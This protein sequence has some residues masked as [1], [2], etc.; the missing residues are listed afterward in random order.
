MKAGNKKQWGSGPPGPGGSWADHGAEGRSVIIFFLSFSFPSPLAAAPCET[1]FLL[2]CLTD[3]YLS[4]NFKDLGHNKKSLSHSNSIRARVTF[5]AVGVTSLSVSP[6]SV[7][8][9]VSNKHNIALEMDLLGACIGLSNDAV[10]CF[11]GFLGKLSQE[12]FK[13]WLV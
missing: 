4:S 5:K 3:A 1:V 10:K 13:C 2:Q 12:T 7:R 6:C 8:C 11:V 9:F